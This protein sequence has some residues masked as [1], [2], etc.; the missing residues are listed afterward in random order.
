VTETADERADRLLALGL[1]LACRV[2]DEPPTAVARGFAHL[3]VGEMRDLVLL[4]AAAVPVDR[5]VSE[6]LGWFAAGVEIPVRRKLQP[7]GTPA[8]Y[9]RHTD[10]GEEP[11]VACTLAYREWDRQRKADRRTAA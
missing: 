10:R 1:D 8:A 3:T 4:L 9:R 6:L 11:C 7:H 5:P 2:R